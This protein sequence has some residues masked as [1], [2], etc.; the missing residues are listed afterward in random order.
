[1]QRGATMHKQHDTGL[2]DF[3][4]RQHKVMARRGLKTAS[5]SWTYIPHKI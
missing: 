3:E 1:M 2:L 5:Q 4:E